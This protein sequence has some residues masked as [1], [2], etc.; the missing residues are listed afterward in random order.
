MPS[1]EINL[2]F[3]PD[4]EAPSA[5][6]RS[7][8]GLNGSISARKLEDLRLVVTELVTNSVRHASPKAGD[9]ILLQIQVDSGVI[10][11]S[12]TDSG[13]GF[14]RPPDKE[15]SHSPEEMA[16]SGWG[17]YMVGRVS[18]RWDVERGDY[19]RVWF[20]MED[21]FEDPDGGVGV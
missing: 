4:L 17:L 12:V 5:A 15:P 10:R 20:E 9:E 3:A 2:A 16:S 21:S 11:G 1:F 13:P 18:E 8:G 7:L 6:R 19:T 14:D